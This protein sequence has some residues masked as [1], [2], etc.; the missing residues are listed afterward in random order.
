V[1]Y[2]TFELDDAGDGVHALEA[3]ASTRPAQHAAVMAEVD[4]VL[5][6]AWRQFPASHGPV[7]D[8]MD[9]DH[10]LQVVAEADGWHTVTLTLS[11]SARFVEAFLAHFGPVVD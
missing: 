5:G 2:L 9:W 6:W 7:D 1:I 3:M 4:A 11:G 10:A 8:G